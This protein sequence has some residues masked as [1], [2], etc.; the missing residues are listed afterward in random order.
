LQPRLDDVDGEYA[1]RA[2]HT[3]RSA[4]GELDGKRE[5]FL[6]DHVYVICDGDEVIERLEVGLRRGGEMWGDEGGWSEG[7]RENKVRERERIG[8]E[9]KGEE[10]M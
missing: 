3:R 4:H 5:L 9:W 8:R 7:E 10:M 6:F 1:R 2:E